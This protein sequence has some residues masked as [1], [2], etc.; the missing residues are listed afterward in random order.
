[1]TDDIQPEFKQQR[2]S[3]IAAQGEDASLKSLTRSW[4]DASCRHNYC[5]HFDWLSRPIIQFPQ[6]VLAMQEILWRVKPDLVVECG[7][8][9]GGSLIFSA[10]MLAMIDYCAAVEAGVTLDPKAGASRV[11]GIDIDIRSPNRRAIEA[12]PLSH[13][14]EM[15]EGSSIAAET[16]ERVRAF[17][18]SFKNIL[19]VLDSNHTHDHVLA[20]LK[21]Y[22]SLTSVGS[23]CAVFDTAIEDMPADMHG[24]R[25]WGPGN[26]P[27]TAV[28][29]FLRDTKD[30][31]IDHEIDNKI[32]ISASTSGYLKRVA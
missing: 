23:Y 3:E 10:S 11:L 7:I 27:K 2:I 5:Y 18:S 25:P 1:M 32:L 22:A 19:V 29:E 26:S 17:A 30:F 13:K 15:I 16:I 12:H 20:E 8:A 28:M 24:N 14:I 31:V 6:D 4:F 9:H 21:A